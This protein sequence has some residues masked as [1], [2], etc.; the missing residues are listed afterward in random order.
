M[1]C[2]LKVDENDGYSVTGNTCPRGAAYGYEEATAPTRTVTSTVRI[3]FEKPVAHFLTAALNNPSDAHPD[4]PLVS[5]FQK[6]PDKIEARLPVKTSAPVPRSKIMEV[7]E[8]INA[9]T[10]NG[11]V[12]IGD[13]IIRDVAGTGSDLVST[14]SM[15]VY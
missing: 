9:V 7:M 14:R 1:G 5:Y 2:H 3:F 15:N 8:A 4:F 13:I 12:H 6:L 10:V 11:P